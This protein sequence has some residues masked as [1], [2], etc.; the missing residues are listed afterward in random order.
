MTTQGE[1]AIRAVSEAFMDSWNDRNMRM[2]AACAFRNSHF[3]GIAPAVTRKAEIAVTRVGRRA[4]PLERVRGPC[5]R[6]AL[7][8]PRRVRT[9]GKS[10]KPV[11]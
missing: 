1:A 2:L 7:A 8:T 11:L 9:K 5:R 6:G 3:T 10:R 4:A